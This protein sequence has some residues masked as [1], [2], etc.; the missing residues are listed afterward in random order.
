MF[1]SVFWYQVLV[2]LEQLLSAHGSQVVDLQATVLL[3]HVILNV[4]SPVYVHAHH[5]I[6]LI[7]I[8]GIT[9]LPVIRGAILGRLFCGPLT[10][11]SAQNLD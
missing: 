4:V 11:W 2:V 8:S 10:G 6:L 1:A 3:H 7:F 5:H 9:R